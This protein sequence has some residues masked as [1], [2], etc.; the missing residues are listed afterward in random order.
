MTGTLTERQK[1]WFESIK[2]SFVGETGKTLEEWVEIAKTCPETKPNA[3]KKWFKDTH[4][5][6]TNRASVVLGEAFPS[7][8]SWQEPEGLR[9]TLWKDEGSLAIL[10]A[11]EAVTTKLEGTVSGQRKAFTAFSREFQYAAAR[12]VKGGHAM[13]GL[14]LE[15]APGAEPRGN[16]SW[17]ERCKVKLLLKSPADVDA[18]LLKQAWERS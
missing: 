4:G 3:R 17:S 6:G 7:S 14:A 2:A 12:P 1:K 9:G 18:T 13:L 16:E 11:I 10:K 5:L 8:A 15:A